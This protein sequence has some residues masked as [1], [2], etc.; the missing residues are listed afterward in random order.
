MGRHFL[1]LDIALPPLP[2]F[3]LVILLA[4]IRLYIARILRLS[5]AL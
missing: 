2:F 3:N 5:G 1:A 4:H